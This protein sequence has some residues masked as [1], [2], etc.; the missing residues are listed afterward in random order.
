MY[1]AT[2]RT[3][4]NT[5]QLVHQDIAKRKEYLQATS[6]YMYLHTYMYM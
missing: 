5:R 1:I 2:V 4:D 6:L 3:T